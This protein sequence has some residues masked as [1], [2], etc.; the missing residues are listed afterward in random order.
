MCL[1]NRKIGEISLECNIYHCSQYWDKSSP[2]IYADIYDLL[3][4]R[5]RVSSIDGRDEELHEPFELH[6]TN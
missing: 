5:G 4:G 3:E 1:Q 2:H 6:R